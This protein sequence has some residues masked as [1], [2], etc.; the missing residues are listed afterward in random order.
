MKITLA[1][2]ELFALAVVAFVIDHVG[3]Y[4]YPDALWLRVFRLFA[5]VWFV[6][7]GY[8]AGRKSDF[9]MWAGV[10][11]LTVMSRSLGFEVL[12]VVAVGTII[13]T[14]LFIDRL[15]EFAVRDWRVFWLVNA[16]L[17]VL[18]PATAQ[19]F[20]Y[21]T[22]AVI[23]ALGGWLLRHKER[24][25]RKIVDVRLYFAFMTLVYLGY[26]ATVFPFSPAQW[27][28]VI[29][30]TALTAMLMYRFKDMLLNSVYRKTEGVIAKT[31]RWIGHKALYIYVLQIM[32]LQ[33]FVYYTLACTPGM[34]FCAAP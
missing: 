8:N 21:G 3:L 5:L 18:I 7:T 11:A 9:W 20:E 6:P 29:I 12:P 15:A 1:S 4:L 32:I 13:A 10:I 27:T 30:S 31:V 33:L 16:A 22:V 24:V 34:P 2:Y 19:V 26:T 17:V 25:H 28:V 14:R 23:I